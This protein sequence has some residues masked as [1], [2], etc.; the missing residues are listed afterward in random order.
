M[1][2]IAH[3]FSIGA[4]LLFGLAA[5]APA[6]ISDPGAVKLVKRIGQKYSAVKRYAFEGTL[7]VGKQKGE[8]PRDVLVQAKIKIEVAPGGKFLLHVTREKDKS[9]YSVIS[10]GHKTWTY[11]PAQAEYSEQLAASKTDPE[12]ADIAEKFSRQMMPL[13]AGIDKMAQV[14]FVRGPVL[15]VVSKKDAQEH[16]TLMYLTLDLVTLALRHLAW[17]NTISHDEKIRA[18]FSFT[19]FRLDNKVPDSDFSF[20][21]PE[22]AK[23]VDSVRIPTSTGSEQL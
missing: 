7:D 8:D 19:G 14:S 2:K 13:L 3:A 22:G 20:T 5:V 10:D 1:S 15:T 11:V 4:F 6:Q 17:I 12:K 18:D 21:P 23:R 9:E 16:Q